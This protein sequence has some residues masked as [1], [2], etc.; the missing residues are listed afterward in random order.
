MA[1][2]NSIRLGLALNFSGIDRFEKCFTAWPL[3]IDIWKRAK[4]DC[5][6]FILVQLC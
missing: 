4:N 3:N 6:L 1:T 2:T 5:I